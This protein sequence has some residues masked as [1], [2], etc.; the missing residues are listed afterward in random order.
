MKL[1]HKS[2]KTAEKREKAYK[3]S[4]GGGLYLEVMPSGSKYWRLKYRINGKEKRLAIGVFP[5]VSLAAARD[6]REKAKK[7]LVENK[8]PSELKKL[9]KLT[10][11]ISSENTFEGIAREW[12]EKQRTGWTAHHADTV[13][14]RLEAD[15]FPKI[16]SRPIA[17]ISSISLL[18]TIQIIEKR[19]AID[20]A[21]R[22][23]QTCGQIFRYS[24][25][26]GRSKDD[27][28]VAL[29]GALTARKVKHRAYLKED[30]LPEYLA[31]L[32]AYD[33]D[34]LTKLAMKVLLLTFL[35]SAELRG[36]R[37]EEIN[38]TK[39]E[40]RIPA[41]RMKMKEEHIVPLADQTIALLKDIQKISGNREHIFPNSVTPNKIMSENTLLYALYRMGYHSRATAHGFRAT[42]S[43]I[44]NENGHRSDIIEAQLAHAERNNVRAAYN[45]AQYLT[46]RREMM[47]WWAD[48]IER[49]KHAS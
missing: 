24:I 12:H 29:K 28:S 39:K 4:D 25:A 15:I 19:G 42:A 37:W 41:E 17:E 38:W 26:T 16:G 20:I 3:L 31:K 44:L 8:D 13:M 14:K 5:Q 33:G 21:H 27:P 6:E 32:K 48:Y 22:A 45:H 7:L 34:R 49:V 46:E 30:E 2:C 35:R 36:G 10:A 40:W 23:R 43:T 47:Q 1:N 9:E 18:S 11:Q